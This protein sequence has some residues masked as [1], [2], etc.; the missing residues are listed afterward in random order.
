MFKSEIDRRLV[1]KILVVLRLLLLFSGVLK[2]GLGVLFF[3]RSI[4][5]LCGSFVGRRSR[6]V[7][8]SIATIAHK[9]ENN[10][11]ECEC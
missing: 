6:S 11:N 2:L 5:I 4:V 10:K 3:S 1:G 8:V 7:R 9:T